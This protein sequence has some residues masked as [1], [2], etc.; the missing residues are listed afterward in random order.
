MEKAKYFTP[1]R[2]THP[3]F[4]DALKAAS[5]KG[6]NVLAYTCTV[7]PD[8]MEIDKPCKIIL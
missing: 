2:D 3:Q 5:E 1:N 4:A 8:S 6:V 7:T